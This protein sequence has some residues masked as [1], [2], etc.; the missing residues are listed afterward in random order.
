MGLISSQ[1]GDIAGITTARE[2]IENAFGWGRRENLIIAPFTI[3]GA[4]RDAG[5]TP[6]TELRP[7]LLLGR[8]TGTSKLTT[9][10]ASNTDGSQVAVGVLPVGLKMT[11]VFTNANL[12]KNYGIIVAGPLQAAKLFGLDAK[13]RADLFGRVIFDDDFTGNKEYPLKLEVAKTGDYTLKVSDSGSLFTNTGAS[14]AVDFTLPAILPGLVYEFLVVADD[15]VTVTSNEGSNIVAFNNPAASSL[16]FST[17]SQKVGGHLLVFSNVAGT[18]WYVSDL[19][20]DNAITV[21]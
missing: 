10:S 11:D 14:G 4:A 12:D 5:N 9:Y 15:T 13:A 1:F 3:D 21:A 2:T 19:S 20:P 6:T 7:G 17:S 16:A 18:L 8:I